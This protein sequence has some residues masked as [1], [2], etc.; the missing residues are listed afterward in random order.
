MKHSPNSSLNLLILPEAAGP[1]PADQ[2]EAGR[3][4]VGGGPSSGLEQAYPG[5]SPAVH[6]ASQGLDALSWNRR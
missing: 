6:W 1:D 2:R 4:E 3:V 5:T